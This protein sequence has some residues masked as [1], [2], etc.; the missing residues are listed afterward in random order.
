M[1]K[2]S[3]ASP[4]VLAEDLEALV[5]TQAEAGFKLAILC[6]A[7]FVKEE[8]FRAPT[9]EERDFGI[10]LPRE[11]KYRVTEFIAVFEKQVRP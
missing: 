7:A 2:P 6:P 10:P 9:K 5:L 3:F 11:F 8:V 4:G 1:I